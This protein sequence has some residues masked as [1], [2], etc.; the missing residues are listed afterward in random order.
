MLMVIYKWRESERLRLSHIRDNGPVTK[1]MCRPVGI[2]QNDDVEKLRL[3]ILKAWQL[4]V[5]SVTTKGARIV[6]LQSQVRL[7]RRCPL[8]VCCRSHTLGMKRP[9]CAA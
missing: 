9:V 1:R 2:R 3:F 7:A 5:P 4:C 8:K 6:R